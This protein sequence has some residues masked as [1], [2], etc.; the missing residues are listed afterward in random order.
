MEVR[1]SRW[2]AAVLV[3]PSE[4]IDEEGMTACEGMI[5]MAPEDEAALLSTQA[6][7]FVVG[8][9]Q[10]LDGGN[11]KWHCQQVVSVEWAVQA[12]HRHVLKTALGVCQFDHWELSA[13]CRSSIRP[14]LS[15]CKAAAEAQLQYLVGVW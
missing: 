12:V 10:D 13:S 11:S 8:K 7:I 3:L 14:K 6:M 15:R 5:A 9:G 2:H 4:G 1:R